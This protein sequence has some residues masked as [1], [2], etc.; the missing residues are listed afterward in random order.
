[1][2]GIPA[3]FHRQL[4]CILLVRAGTGRLR[5]PAQPGPAQ[6]PATRT[7]RAGQLTPY[8]SRTPTLTR[9]PTN[10]ATP[11]PLPSPSPTPRTHAVSGEDMFGIAWRYGI[12]LEDLMAANPEVN[13]NFLASATLLVIPAIEPAGAIQRAADPTP[14][15]LE[16]G[17][18]NC[19]RSADG[20]VWCFWPVHNPHRFA[21]ENIS[22]IFRLAD[23][24]AQ[25]IQPA[26]VSAAGCAAAWR[27]PAADGLLSSTTA[28]PIPGQRGNPECAAQP[29]R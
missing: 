17:R 10:P 12:T 7:P 25:N 28:R 11:T 13:P 5:C 8:S 19:A 24:D 16:T 26:G 6:A 21:L 22:A 1:M 14:I 18:L 15:P 27:Q 20:G 23:R 4:A 29:G 9:T 2:T 3:S